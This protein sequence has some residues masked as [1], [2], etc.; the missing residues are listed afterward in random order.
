MVVQMIKQETTIE[1]LVED[2]VANGGRRK[3]VKS[4]SPVSRSRPWRAGMKQGLAKKVAI[5][6]SSNPATRDLNDFSVSSAGAVTYETYSQ[7][8]GLSSRSP[9]MSPNRSPKH[10]FRSSASRLQAKINQ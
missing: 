3:V 5:D 4:P 1:Q 6:L 8:D 2:Q 10:N 7:V 9:E